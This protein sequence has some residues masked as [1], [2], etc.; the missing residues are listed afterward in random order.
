M[1]KISTLKPIFVQF[2]PQQLEKGILY[3]SM[4]YATA[5]H[6]CCCGCENKVVTPFKKG[7]W[8]LILHD[9]T[10]TIRPSIGNWNFACQ[11]HY[12][13]SQNEIQW[14]RKFDQ[15]EIEEVQALHESTL[16]FIYTTNRNNQES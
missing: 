2:V 11:S 3:I 6:L 7:R 1:K 13:I 8:V 10:I 15:E 14:L 12:Y 16:N 5:S 9:R 4:E